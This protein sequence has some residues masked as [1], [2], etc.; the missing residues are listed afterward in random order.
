VVSL[1][2]CLRCGKWL[3][4]VVEVSRPIVFEALLEGVN[5]LHLSLATLKSEED[6]SE[7]IDTSPVQ[8]LVQLKV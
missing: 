5:L 2:T 6:A 7:A 4:N 8:A 3:F 1:S